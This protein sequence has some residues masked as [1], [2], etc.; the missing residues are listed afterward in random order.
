MTAISA[1]APTEHRAATV[2]AFFVIAYLGISLPVVGV[3]ALTLGIGLRNAG[4]TFS[5]CVL[6]LALGVG[7]YLARRPPAPR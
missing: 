3:G 6:A 1:A 2:S 4:L 5:G 7:L